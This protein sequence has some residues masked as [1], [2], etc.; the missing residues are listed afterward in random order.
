MSEKEDFEKAVDLLLNIEGY[1]ST[2][3]NGELAIWGI[4]EKWYPAVVEE[5]VDLPPH[6][7][8][9]KA[10]RFYY[11]KFW[12]PLVIITGYNVGNVRLQQ[13][14]FIQAV[15]QGLG[16][17]KNMIPPRAEKTPGDKVFLK[18]FLC[19]S[20]YRY[21]EIMKNNPAEMLNFSG[22]M[23]RILKIYTTIK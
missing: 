7:S 13:A 19:E 17:V 3:K 10:K 4:T 20:Q 15:N 11:D 18:I 14:A 5:L 1:R 9:E 22:W 8:R 23:S 21:C 6:L 16:T 12:F 2:D